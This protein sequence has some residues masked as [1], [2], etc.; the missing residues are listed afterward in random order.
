VPVERNQIDPATLPRDAN[1]RWD[2]AALRRSVPNPFYGVPGTGE[3]GTRATILAGQLLRP[4]PQFNNV[5]ALQV[6]EGSKRQYHSF[7]V[8]L[9]KR[10]TRIWGGNFSYTWSRVMDNQWGENTSYGSRAATPQNFYDLEAEYGRAIY[11]KPHRIIISPIVRIPGPAHVA[12]LL[13][14]GWTVSAIGEFMS[15]PTATAYNTTNS[16]ANLGL[17]GGLQRLNPTD[18]AVETSGSQADRLASADHPAAAWFEKAAYVDPGIGAYGTLPRTDARGRYPFFRNIDAVFAK[19]VTFPGARKIDVR[20]E[21]LNLTN[22]PQLSGAQ[23]NFSSAQFGRITTTR[24]F[25]RLVQMMFR[26]TF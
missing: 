24:G 6:T 21:I 18:H 16:E 17:F 13:L 23:T 7:T 14:G 4:Y 2:A 20:F 22:N 8:K 10:T 5:S 26:Y 9:D 11:D 1:G 15:G 12:S 25:P 3:L 19:S